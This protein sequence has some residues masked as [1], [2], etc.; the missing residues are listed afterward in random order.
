QWLQAMKEAI[1]SLRENGT[2]KMVPQTQTKDRKVITCHWMYVV[3]KNEKGE[4]KRFKA[5]LVTHGF[6]PRAG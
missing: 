4:I 2:W 5:R 6:K 1:T 3:K